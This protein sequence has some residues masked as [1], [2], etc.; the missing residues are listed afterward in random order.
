M[1][2]DRITEQQIRDMLQE[3]LKRREFHS[4]SN[5]NLIVKLMN[6]IW[7]AIQEWIREILGY[8]QPDFGIQLNPDF[9]NSVLRTATRILLIS[10]AVVLLFF[11]ARVIKKK[12]YLGRRIKTS[13]IPDAHDFLNKPGQAMDNYYR[14][15]SSGDYSRAL[16]YLFVA[17]LL[18]FDRRKM[19]KIEKWKTNRMYIREIG[20][21]NKALISPMQE[22]TA[23]FNECCYRN[24]NIDESSVEKWFEFYMNQKEKPV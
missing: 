8:K 23:L 16:R 15:M 21:K 13:D 22:F 12:I 6:S 18:E 17:L 19:I 1:Q 5:Q 14:Y 20:L 9:D 2:T 10:F 7:E 3:I 4:D 24:K 11:L